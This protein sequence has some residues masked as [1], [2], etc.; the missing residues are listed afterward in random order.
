MGSIHQ[1]GLPLHHHDLRRRRQDLQPSLLQVYGDVELQKEEC[2]NHVTK[3]LG[4]ALR[5]LATSGKQAGIILRGRGY[6]KLKQTTLN[7]LMAYYGKA[8][9]DHPN[10]VSSMQS[11]I[12]ATFEHAISTDD[13][14]QHDRC[15]VG[16]DSW[17]FYQKALATGQEPGPH[18]VNVE[19]T[20]HRAGAGPPSGECRR[21]SPPGRSRA[22][23][24]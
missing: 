6:G 8:V 16:V 22:P 1:P 3:R 24:G 10:D 23:I 4:T 20:R 12:L 9:R 18:R 2:I 15:P 5:K 7:K 21:H 19:G 11:P 13:N 14:P 17:C